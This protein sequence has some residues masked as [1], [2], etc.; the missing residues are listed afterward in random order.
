MAKNREVGHWV[1]RLF[2]LS[3]ALLIALLA[4]VL[5]RT[6]PGLSVWLGVLVLS[7]TCLFGLFFP[8][9]MRGPYRLVEWLFGPVGRLA[10]LLV[11]ALVFFGVFT[12]FAAVLHLTGWDPLA[13]QARKREESAWRVRAKKSDAYHWQY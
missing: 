12:P 6:F 1:L 2:A 7:G 11:M 8:A 5:K 4:L 9:A 13:R 10:N 3:W